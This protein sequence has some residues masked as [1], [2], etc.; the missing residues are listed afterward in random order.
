MPDSATDYVGFTVSLPD[1]PCPR[2]D[3]ALLDLEASRYEVAR[4]T[5]LVERLEK[6][7][8]SLDRNRIYQPR[9][10]DAELVTVADMCKLF[11]RAQGSISVASRLPD[12]PQPVDSIRLG[13]RGRKSRRWRTAEVMAWAEK[14]GW[15]K[16]KPL[17]KRL[18]R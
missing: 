12:F 16:V 15:L 17:P 6:R 9:N 14:A 7:V 18:P 13:R 10:T 1:C 2:L 11:R 5:R 3:D 4:L 8:R